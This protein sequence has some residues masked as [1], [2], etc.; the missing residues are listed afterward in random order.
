MKILVLGSNGQLG[1][2]LI[3]QMDSTGFD[4]VYASRADIDVSNLVTTQKAISLINPNAVVNATAYTAVDEAEDDQNTAAEI[5][6]FAVANL[7]KI[8][9]QLD[10]WLVHV[11]T[12]YVFD[13]LSLRPYRE[14]DLTNPLGVYG[15]TKLKGEHAI[16][17]S[18]CKYLILRTAW[19]FSEYGTNFLKTMLVLGANREELNIVGDQIGCPTYGQDIAKVIVTILPKLNSQTLASGIIHYCGNT[20]CSWYEFASVIFEESKQLGLKTPKF[21]NSINTAD[22]PTRASRPTYSVLACSK[23]SN[24][25]G[26]PPSNWRHGIKCALAR[27]QAK[28]E[29]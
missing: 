8:C 19:L 9:N 16:Q 14:D 15:E 1:Q 27:I 29:S 10:C 26:I 13:G 23:I 6:H 20:P 24:M 3:D 7:A 4:V 21:I 2:C 5:N 28:N 11:S 18:G 25:F 22:Y 17:A 12:D